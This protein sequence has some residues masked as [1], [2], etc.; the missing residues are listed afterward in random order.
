MLTDKAFPKITIVTPSYNQGPF[1]EETIQSVLGQVYPNLDYIIIDGGSTDG[2]VGIIRKY[3]EKLSYWISEKDEGQADAINKGFARAAGTLLGWLNSDDILLPG[4]LQLLAEAHRGHPDSIIAGDVK[5][6][7]ENGERAVI[8]QKGL[9]KENFAASWNQVWEQ[10][11]SYHQPGIFFPKS[12][13]DMCGPLDIGFHYCFDSD[14][15][16]RLLDQRNVVYLKKV[17][18]GFRLHSSSKTMSR[19]DEFESESDR[20]LRKYWCRDGYCPDLR[21]YSKAMGAK[22]AVAWKHGRIRDGIA[23]ARRGMRLYPLQSLSGFVQAVYRGLA[24]R[25]NG[26]A[27]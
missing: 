11:I 25:M 16:F 5:N 18:A 17:I 26:R 12:A 15:M 23:I 3:E 22:C 6:F 10:K 21:D 13:W 20:V 8:C 27:R 14:L 9:S 2:S 19:G 4:A 7:D 1:I 24:G